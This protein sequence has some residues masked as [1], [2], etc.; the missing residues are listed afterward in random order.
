MDLQMT[1]ETAIEIPNRLDPPVNGPLEPFWS[2]K[3]A[4]KQAID[5]ERQTPV[6]K[7]QTGP[8]VRRL[9]GFLRSQTDEKWQSRFVPKAWPA[10]VEMDRKTA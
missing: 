1:P 5:W 6:D 10:D 3:S 7:L 8:L 2:W 9:K 4:W